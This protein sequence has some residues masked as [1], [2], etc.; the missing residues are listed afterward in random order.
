MKA[1]E[2]KK[3]EATYADGTKV[4]T[5]VIDASTAMSSA[6]MDPF[7]GAGNGDENADD[8]TTAAGATEAYATEARK[9]NGELRDQ[10]S[11]KAD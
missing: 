10:V 3:L 1:D 5:D 6:G 2:N 8:P 4:R 11:Q 7:S 9:G